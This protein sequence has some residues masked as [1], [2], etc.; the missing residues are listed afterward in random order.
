MLNNKN[1][2]QQTISNN[3]KYNK[4][5]N[6][7]IFRGIYEDI[8]GNVV[9]DGK[10]LGTKPKQ[11]ACKAFSKISRIYEK[12]NKISSDTLIFFGLKECTRKKKVKKCYWYK[13]NIK[14]LDKPALSRVKK[15][16]STGSPL[17]DDK[18]GK[19]VIDDKTGKYVIDI[20][21]CKPL[22]DKKTG[23]PVEI[24]HKYDNI[25]KKSKECECKHLLNFVPKKKN[26][27]T[28]EELSENSS[29]SENSSI[30]KP[31]KIKKKK[32]KQD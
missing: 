19:P 21:T 22:L 14:K 17:I 23:K 28:E 18:T 12:A 27:N 6:K 30:K 11:A 8:D 1:K 25:V 20:K 32:K 7:R 16:M 24:Y 29:D 31:K 9:I 4:N 13:G 5:K 26:N 15:D 3:I 10:Y 2:N